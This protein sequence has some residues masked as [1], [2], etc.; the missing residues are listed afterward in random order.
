MPYII[1]R[2]QVSNRELRVARI[3]HLRRIRGSALTELAICMLPYALVMLGVM[4]LGQISLGK[5]EIFKAVNWA[6]PAPGT[7]DLSGDVDKYFFLGKGTASFH[8]ESPYEPEV[9]AETEEPVLP[10]TASDIQAAATR[11]AVHVSQTTRVVDGEVVVDVSVN[12]TRSGKALQEAGMLDLSGIVGKTTLD[13]EDVGDLSY[14]LD[15]DATLSQEV[16]DTLAS[17]VTYSRSQ[18]GY[19]YGL[20][21]DMGISTPLPLENDESGQA[22]KFRDTFK[23]G[24]EAD[25]NTFACQAVSPNEEGFR[26][27]HADDS[28]DV[29]AITNAGFESD[30]GNVDPPNMQEPYI[31]TGDDVVNCWD[32]TFAP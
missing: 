4:L 29:D 12:C 10:Y 23:I 18:A 24:G 20:G 13:P 31:K 11:E 30:D 32:I 8:E 6:S 9:D 16:A 25:D 28:I 2:A 19:E 27:F 14:N 7:Q 26:G 1:D 5:Q 22:A 15:V 21:K 17:W 3:N